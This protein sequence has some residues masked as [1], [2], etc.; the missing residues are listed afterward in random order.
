MLKMLVLMALSN[1]F[2]PYHVD[3]QPLFKHSSAN[4]KVLF[5]FTGDQ[6]NKYFCNFFRPEQYSSHGRRPKDLPT[7]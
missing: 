7:A 6:I 5:S 4:I 2:Q 1:H 3:I